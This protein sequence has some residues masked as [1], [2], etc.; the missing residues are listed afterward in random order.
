[1]ERDGQVQKLNNF[2]SLITST[3]ADLLYRDKGLDTPFSTIT[4]SLRFYPPG[5]VRFD[6]N[7]TNDP[8]DLSFET[9]DLT[10]RFAYTGKT[11]L[12]PGFTDP[13]RQDYAGL[14]D[15]TGRTPNYE[16]SEPTANPWNVSL[17]Y[18]LNRTF[19]TGTQAQWLELQTGF[20]LSRN[21]RVDYSNRYD[22]TNREIAYQEFSIYRD[23]HCWQAR[24]VRRFQNNRWEYY[25]RV[26][27]K[28]H[29]D[30]YAERGL[31]SLDRSY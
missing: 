17:I 12:L 16:F 10:T 4:N 25:F 3:T 23:L 20:N 15:L 18:R 13:V 19:E 11:G 1:M 26:N 7:F 30:L 5:G 2:M 14:K 6:I 31:R 21:W 22:I 9:L 29:P 24:F 27:I 8:R 28:A